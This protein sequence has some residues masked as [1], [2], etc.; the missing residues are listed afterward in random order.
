[1]IANR[2]LSPLL[3]CA[4]LSL[5]FAS[6]VVRGETI[7]RV[8]SSRSGSGIMKE[9][10]SGSKGKQLNAD[11]TIRDLLDHPAFAGFGRLLLPWDDRSYDDAMRLRNVGSL[12]PYHTHVDPRRSSPA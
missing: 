4:V 11:D 7:E 3:A 6:F 5:L 9:Q 2:G 12:L 10:V 8:V 1:M